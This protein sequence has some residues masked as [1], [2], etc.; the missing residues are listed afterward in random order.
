MDFCGSLDRERG[1]KGRVVFHELHQQAVLG[2]EVK[3]VDVESTV[4]RKN[5]GTAGE[6]AKRL[7]SGEEL[8]SYFE[9]E[10]QP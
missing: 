8:H 3:L 9:S 2:A 5:A 4:L 7:A 6:Y 1:Q 10:Q